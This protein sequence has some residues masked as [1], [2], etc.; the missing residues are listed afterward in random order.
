M[1]RRRR[2]LE[3]RVRLHRQ[4]FDRDKLFRPALLDVFELV[5][6]AKIR[7]S[8]RLRIIGR[9]GKQRDV[10][11]LDDAESPSVTVQLIGAQCGMISTSIGKYCGAPPSGGGPPMTSPSA[12]P[13]FSSMK[14]SKASRD[15][16]MS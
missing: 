13:S 11:L 3:F 8:V 9:L 7:F 5:A 16:Q 6:S 2:L 12:G 10:V 15:S 4:R 14:R 1:P